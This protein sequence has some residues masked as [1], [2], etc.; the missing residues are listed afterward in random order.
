M[1]TKEYK[2]NLFVLHEAAREE[3]TRKS[4]DFIRTEILVDDTRK[5]GWTPLRVIK[6]TKS[7]YMMKYRTPTGTFNQFYIFSKDNGWD[8]M[9]DIDVTFWQTDGEELAKLQLVA[10]TIKQHREGRITDEKINQ[11]AKAYCL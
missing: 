3:S 8:L 2:K 1:D 7:I 5:N 11:L 4:L 10:D 9:D 6:I